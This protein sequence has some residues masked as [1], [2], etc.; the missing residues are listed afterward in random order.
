V[1]EKLFSRN[2]S[3]ANLGSKVR[4]EV[5][6]KIASVSRMMERLETSGNSRT[7]DRPTTSTS[8]VPPPTKSF[9]ERV[10]ESNSDAATAGGGTTT[11][12]TSACNFSA[13]CVAMSSSN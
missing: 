2:S 7:S 5:N 4:R 3:M 6:A 9:T 13:P 1:K 12:S 10:T 8:E 11:T